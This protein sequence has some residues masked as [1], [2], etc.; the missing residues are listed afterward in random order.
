MDSTTTAPV[1]IYQP[2]LYGP[3]PCWN[4]LTCSFIGGPL[5]SPRLCA[6]C[7]GPLVPLV[8]LHQAPRR[9]TTQVWACNR[10]TCCRTLFPDD[11]SLRNALHYGGNGVVV[12]F[13]FHNV[14]ATPSNTAPATDPRNEWDFNTDVDK[15]DFNVEGEE[16]ND[17]YDLEQQLSSLE[18]RNTV[19]STPR[20]LDD[21]P[22]LSTEG[23][24]GYGLHSLPEPP[25]RSAQP[26]KR[27]SSSSDA[28][29]QQMLQQYLQVEE[30]E[31][32]RQLLLQS[33]AVDRS[34]QPSSNIGAWEEPDETDAVTEDQEAL[35]SYTERLQRV[36]RQVVRCGGGNGPLWFVPVR[37]ARSTDT[38]TSG[39]TQFQGKSFN[40]TVFYGYAQP[41]PPCAS[42]GAPLQW[43]LQLLP[44]LLHAL[45]VDDHAAVTTNNAITGLP[46][47]MD[48]GNIAIY[49]CSNRS[50]TSAQAYCIVQDSID[51]RAYAQARSRPFQPDHNV[52]PSF[53]ADSL[54]DE[55]DGEEDGMIAEEEEED[56][57]ECI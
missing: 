18:T 47:G 3:K 7:E 20:R 45:R 48:W 28:K 10:V 52:P 32:L 27:H 42:C 2:I 46:Q 15:E 33:G 1:R 16:S 35:Q 41:I 38:E 55:I 50:C 39:D 26:S 29:I 51:G 44:S 40:A 12:A 14:A 22:K 11:D 54:E 53:D 57:D 34:N 13:Q 24:P 31:T 21:Q 37:A 6:V 23:F 56:D 8:Q 4:D 9:T 43:E 19:A 36:P 17:L 49:T 30:D 5:E 25:A